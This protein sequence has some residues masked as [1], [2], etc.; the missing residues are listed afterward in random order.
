MKT[1]VI[2]IYTETSPENVENVQTIINEVLTNKEK[3]LT[4]ERF[5]IIKD[6]YLVKIKKDNIL[7]HNKLTKYIQ[8]EKWNIETIINTITLNDVYNIIDKYFNFEKYYKS[9]YNKEFN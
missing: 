4:Q 9:I 8:P 5:N 6:N 1:S 7:V 2:N 3:Y